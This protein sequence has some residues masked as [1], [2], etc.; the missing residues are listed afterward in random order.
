MRI[1][2]KNIRKLIK[3]VFGLM[4][5]DVSFARKKH[6]SNFEIIDIN[7]IEVLWKNDQYMDRYYRGLK[8]AGVQETD[9]FFKQ[10]RHYVLQQAV[11]Y[12]LTIEGKGS[13]AECGCWKGH[14]SY[15]I[16][17]ILN[18]HNFSC[19]FSIFDS[20]EG[21]LSDK[22]EEDANSRIEMSKKEIDE[23]KQHFSSTEDN[24]HSTLKGFG[25]YKLY[26]GW[27][28]DRFNEVKD[29]DFIFVHIDVDLYDPILDSLNFF[30]PR[31]LDGGVILIDDYGFTQF[32]GARKAVD[33]FL[34][35]NNCRM[36]LSSICGGMLI[37]K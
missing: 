31:L 14:S 17:D 34:S 7:T 36:T 5:L 26:K 33:L 23:E 32:P 37:V 29:R 35:E 12:A 8:A 3:N 18:E 10:G 30:F 20:F 6:N 28:P 19:E 11:E 2:K 4:G 9:N 25:F 24:L 1:V 15:I 16:S 13:V 22:V 21:G 27:V